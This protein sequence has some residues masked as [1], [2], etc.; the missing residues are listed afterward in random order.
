VQENE[1]GGVEVDPA[2]S[3]KAIY[4]PALAEVAKREVQTKLRR[5]INE[6]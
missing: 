2:A 5:V 3:M 4:N 6:L 1:G